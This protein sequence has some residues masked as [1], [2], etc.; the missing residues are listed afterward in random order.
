MKPTTNVARTPMTTVSKE[1]P[2]RVSGLHAVTTDVGCSADGYGIDFARARRVKPSAVAS[3][4][5][6]VAFRHR[7]AAG[8]VLYRVPPILGCGAPLPVGKGICRAAH[9]AQGVSI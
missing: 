9:I 7:T 8:D 1:P 3:V 6:F 2:P 5:G 4:W